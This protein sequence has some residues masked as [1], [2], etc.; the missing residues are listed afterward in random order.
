MRTQPPAS[1][2]TPGGEN[3]GGVGNT[4]IQQGMHYCR[5]MNAL[6][7]LKSRVV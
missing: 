5:F 7:L 3:S 4:R 6:V 1:G 2:V